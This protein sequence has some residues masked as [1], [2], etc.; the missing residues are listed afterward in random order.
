MIEELNRYKTNMEVAFNEYV[1]G[2]IADSVDELE[3]VEHKALYIDRYIELEK[4]IVELFKM[5]Y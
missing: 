3:D 5:K 4:R 1:D 2:L